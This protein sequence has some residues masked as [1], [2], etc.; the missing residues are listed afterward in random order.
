MHT[1]PHTHAHIYIGLVGKVFANGPVNWG[2]IPGWIIPETQKMVLDAA[3]L[4]TQHY[5]VQIRVK[6]SSPGK[7][8]ALREPLTTFTNFTLYIYIYIYIVAFNIRERKFK[9][10]K[11]Q[12]YWFDWDKFCCRYSSKLVLHTANL[13]KNNNKESY[14]TKN[15]NSK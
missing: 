7:G 3:L 4:N 12:S 5:K 9:N 10:E 13:K 14:G 2:S 6:W 8:L 1:H 11:F 15:T